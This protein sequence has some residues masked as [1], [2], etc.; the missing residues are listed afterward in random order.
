MVL[1]P[2][3]QTLKLLRG[4]HFLEKKTAGGIKVLIPVDQ[5]SNALPIINPDDVFAFNVFPTSGIFSEFTDISTVSNDKILRFSNEGLGTDTLELAVSEATKEGMF[6]G[7]PAIAKIEIQLSEVSSGLDGLPPVY[8][9]VFKSKSVRWRYYFVS[10]TGTTN[11][12]I[13][14]R[15]EQLIFNELEI[16]N[17]TSDKIAASLRLNFPDTQLVVF[18]SSASIAYSNRAIKNIQLLRN[19]DVVIQHLPNPDVGDDGIQIIKVK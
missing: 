5:E 2:E 15:D 10:S 11:L 1:I 18:E 12:T 6:N 8:Q 13:E 7:F 4:Q 19:G 16:Q 9:A 17:D 14:Q 3:K